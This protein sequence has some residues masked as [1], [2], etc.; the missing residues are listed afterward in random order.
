M[1]NK[2]APP[3]CRKCEKTLTWPKAYV[4][5][6]IPVELDGSKHYCDEP[7][8]ELEED[9]IGVITNCP[10][11]HRQT[12]LRKGNYYDDSD[13]IMPHSCSMSEAKEKEPEIIPKIKPE[14]A[15]EKVHT[16]KEEIQVTFQSAA[17]IQPIPGFQITKI[18]L[19]REDNEWGSHEDANKDY[20]TG[21]SDTKGKGKKI[22]SAIEFSPGSSDRQTIDNT[23]EDNA[24]ILRKHNQRELQQ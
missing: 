14:P 20:G 3:K 17:D 22:L 9:D 4:P 2:K 6:N 23:I 5:G 16:A 8:T 21:T 10:N 7:P 11:C 1:K 15:P 12:L 18:M 13:C 19:S 24:V